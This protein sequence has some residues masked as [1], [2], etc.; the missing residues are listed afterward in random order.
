[1]GMEVAK[2][3][4]E[5]REAFQRTVDMARN[6]FGNAA[7]F[8]EKFIPAARHIEIQV[9]G[10]GQGD[11]VHCGERECSAQRRNQKV[12]EEA[13]SPFVEEHAGSFLRELAR[14]SLGRN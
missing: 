10:D 12:L 8:V 9:F 6:L 5:L 7:V 3:E 2:T 11:V 13:P 1:M 14:D 4:L